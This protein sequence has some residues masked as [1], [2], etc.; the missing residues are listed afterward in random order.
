MPKPVVVNWEVIRLERGH[1]H[2]V[3]ERA[4]RKAAAWCEYLESHANR[5]YGGAVDP[6]AINAELLTERRDKL[7]DGFTPREIKQKG[8]AG[9][10]KMQQI[11]DALNELVT[12]NYLKAIEQKKASKGGR[13]SWRYYWNPAIK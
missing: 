8:W 7:P 11:G 12:C 9:L 5:I 10:T 4:A 13:P 6:T 1:N 2:P 3:G